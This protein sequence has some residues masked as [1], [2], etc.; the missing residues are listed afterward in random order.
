MSKLAYASKSYLRARLMH[1]TYG[2]LL[3]SFLDDPTVISKVAEYFK[4]EC[5]VG[6]KTPPE[7]PAA[8][9]EDER[10]ET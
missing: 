6:R 7:H 2:A 5:S 8:D 9:D 1:R 4:A 3:S 10:R